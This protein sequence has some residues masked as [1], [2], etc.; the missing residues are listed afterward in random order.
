MRQSEKTKRKEFIAWDQEHGGHLWN[1]DRLRSVS[2]NHVGGPAAVLSAGREPY[3]W[4]YTVAGRGFRAGEK[5]GLPLSH[6]SVSK[7]VKGRR[8]LRCEANKIG[9]LRIQPEGMSP[10]RGQGIEGVDEEGGEA[11]KTQS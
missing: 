10:C 11:L 5:R 2:G 9:G 7:A 6:L 8:M 4:K 1:E 3:R